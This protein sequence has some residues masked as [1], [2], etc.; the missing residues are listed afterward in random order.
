MKQAFQFKKKFMLIGLLAA[1]LPL[2]WNACGSRKFNS[3]AVSPS[4]ID[5]DMDNDGIP[6]SEDPV[7]DRPTCEDHPTLAE[8]NPGNNNYYLMSQNAQVKSNSNVDVL[9]VVDN[10]GSMAQEQIDIGNKIDGFL[11]KIKDLNWQI[12]VTTTDP[13]SYTI[14]DGGNTRYWSDG[15]FRAFDGDAGSKFI[16]KATEFTA[17]AAQTKLAAAIAVGIKGSGAERGINATYRAIQRS[18]VSGSSQ[19]SF[20]RTGARLAVVVISDED[21]C[22]T[23]PSS[24]CPDRGNSVPQNLINLVQQ[25]FGTSKVFSFNSIV[26]KS[27]C[28]TGGTI[29]NTYLNLSALTGGTTGE[30]C[31]TNFTTP[32]SILGNKVV[33]L[34]KSVSLACLP[35]DV[36]NDGQPD[37]DVLNNSGTIL[38][39][40]YTMSGSTVTFNNPLAEGT[41]KL[42]YFCKH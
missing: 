6:D 37:L 34:V 12:A 32:L 31:S 7:D 41:Y 36:D 42:N 29:G 40:G 27:S 39:V 4:V 21:E 19:N 13:N 38:N 16:L 25:R 3:Q 1:L 20:F 23:G 15:Q 35:Q 9:F 18:S 8:C 28:T 11:N 17:A 26:Y 24:G 22:S 33:D 14:D 10:S 30:V 2:G 5:D